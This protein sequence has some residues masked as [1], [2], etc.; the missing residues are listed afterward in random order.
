LKQQG[1][2]IKKVLNDRVL[3]NQNLRELKDRL[4][5][6]KDKYYQNI[7]KSLVLKCIR[8]EFNK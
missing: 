4:I 7:M 1:K 8:P 2:T 6:E 3:F 5:E